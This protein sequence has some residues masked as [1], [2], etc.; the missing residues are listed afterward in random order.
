MKRII[1][2]IAAILMFIPA[3]AMAESIAVEFSYTGEAN[4][5]SLYMDEVAICQIVKT[6][7]TTNA[8][9]DYEMLCDSGDIPSGW[10]TFSLTA[11]QTSGEETRHSPAF[12]WFKDH[13][14]TGTPP[15]V[16]TITINPGSSAP[17]VINGTLQ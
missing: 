6:D 9:N 17:I 1:L 3:A 10:H 4:G 12:P 5:Y 7:V 2:L 15:T 16:I 14:D 8:N 11:T 13:P